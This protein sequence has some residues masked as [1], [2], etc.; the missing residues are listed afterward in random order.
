MVGAWIRRLWP[1]AI[2]GALLIG[3]AALSLLGKPGVHRVISKH[4]APPLDTRAPHASPAPS[5]TF[6][7]FRPAKPVANLPHWLIDVVGY[8]CTAILLPI[9]GYLLWILIRP[10]FNRQQ[11]PEMAPIGAAGSVSRRAAV[12]AAVDT[13]IAELAREDGDARAAVIACWVR[14]E[15][16]AALAGTERATGETSSDLVARLLGDHQISSDALLSL[17]ALYRSARYSSQYIESSMREQAYAALGRLREELRY[18]RSG[19]LA[20]DP[21]DGEP[22]AGA[23]LRPRPDPSPEARR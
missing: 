5:A 9:L 16:V 13:S 22:P 23:S 21:V 10:L 11:S 8:G 4:P 14:L 2:V 18:S 12:L 6:A 15:D 20:D 7:S 19:P 1:L 17:A 3:V